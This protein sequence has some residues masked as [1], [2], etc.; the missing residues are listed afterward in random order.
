M[1]QRRKSNLGTEAAGLLFCQFAHTGIRKAC[2]VK[3]AL[4]LRC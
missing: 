1:R 4:V 3:K 2:E